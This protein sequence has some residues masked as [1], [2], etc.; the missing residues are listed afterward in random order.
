MNSD[1][2]KRFFAKK[3]DNNT[4]RFGDNVEIILSEISC[5]NNVGE[6]TMTVFKDEWVY[7]YEYNIFLKGGEK[8]NKILSTH[9]PIDLFNYIF[10]NGYLDYKKINIKKKP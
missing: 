7:L 5:I 2:Y 9:E 8:L 10:N 3:T 4:V 1:C 6:R